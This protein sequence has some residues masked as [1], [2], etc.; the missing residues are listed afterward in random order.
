MSDRKVW[1]G[2]DTETHIIQPGNITP[3]LVSMQLYFPDDEVARVY[4]RKDANAVF[5]SML[6][7]PRI[8]LVGHMT[9]YDIGVMVNEDPSLLPLV[10]ECLG[11]KFRCTKVQEQLLRIAGDEPLKNL[12]LSDL[13][14][15][16]LKIDISATKGEDT[17]RMRY[18]LL[19]G[20]DPKRWPLEAYDYAVDDAEYAY[21]VDDRQ[22]S[23]PVL[24]SHPTQD[25]L[26][27]AGRQLEAMFALHLMRVWGIRVD[28]ARVVDLKK[29]ISEVVSLGEETG[30]SLGFVREDGSRDMGA[31]RDLVSDAYGGEPPYTLKGNI[32]TSKEVLQNSGNDELIAYAQGAQARTLYST[33]IPILE[34]GF[35]SPINANFNVLVRS[36]RTSCWGPNLQNIPRYSGIREAF[37]PRPGMTFCSVDFDCIELRALSQ[38]CLDWFGESALARA[39]QEGSDPHLLL[40][41]HLLDLPYDEALSRR[42]DPDVVSMRSLSKVMNFGFAGGLSAINFLKYAKGYG[43]VLDDDPQVAAVKATRLRDQWFLRWSEMRHYF[44]RI[45]RMTRKGTCVI[46][47]PW[48]GR[49]RGGVSFCSAANSFFQGLTAD[50]CKLALVAFSRECYLAPKSSPLYGVRPLIFLHDEI[51]AEGPSERA[52]EWSTEMQRIMVEEMSRVVPDIPVTC[53]AVLMDRWYKSACPIFRDGRLV[54][55]SPDTAPPQ[56]PMSSAL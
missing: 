27:D 31:L 48:S 3:R 35:D 24:A 55:W 36:G 47:Q 37:V 49:V 16:Y 41:S 50:G 9:P 29:E 4:L 7:N 42:Y 18:H 40:A 15:K 51:L 5:R 45:S 39:F 26:N 13:V 17:W 43:L 33:F 52:H 54:A 12:R 44:R 46:K 1:V 22:R 19:D 56:S 10:L 23:T 32:Q 38:V 30:K 14:L 11:T 20:I 8:G 34:K 6:E 21:R 25:I 28:P 53:E 2:F